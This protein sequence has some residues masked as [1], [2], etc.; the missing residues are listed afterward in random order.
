[1]RSIAAGST[2]SSP[3]PVLD[4]DDVFKVWPTNADRGEFRSVMSAGSRTALQSLP[5]DEDRLIRNAYL[6]L[7]DC[8]DSW[9]REGCS[10]KIR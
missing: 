2:Q 8:F 10:A 3:R 5:L 6:F 9:I 7:A 4:P 1:M